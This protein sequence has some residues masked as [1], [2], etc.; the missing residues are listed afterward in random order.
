MVGGPVRR[1]AWLNSL[2]ACST[3]GPKRITVDTTSFSLRGLMPVAARVLADS[4]GPMPNPSELVPEEED[5]VLE[6]SL[7]EAPVKRLGKGS[8]HSV[9]PVGGLEF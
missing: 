2:T 5:A 1:A 3:L 9:V 8:H 4:F 6:G 7:L